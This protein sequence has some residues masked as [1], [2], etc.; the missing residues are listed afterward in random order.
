MLRS[1][2][3][4]RRPEGAPCS[5][6]SHAVIHSNKPLILLAEDDPTLRY[7]LGSFLSR[8]GYTVVAVEDGYQA[9]EYAVRD[10]PDLL[11]LDVHMPAGDGFSVQDRVQKN[12]ELAI[13]P[14]IYMTHDHSGS[15]AKDADAHHAVAL[16]YKP[17]DPQDLLEHI[18]RALGQND[19]AAA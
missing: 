14:V 5:T 1:P 17:F 10:N 2:A 18:E 16:L 11:V 15:I 8:Q 19:R 4:T 3:W 6:W 7:E 13:K 12:P 9:V